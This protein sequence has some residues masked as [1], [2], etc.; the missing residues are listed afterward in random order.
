[1]PETNR[2]PH[3]PGSND[4]PILHFVSWAHGPTGSIGGTR[5][6]GAFPP[7]NIAFDIDRLNRSGPN[8]A[9]LNPSTATVVTPVQERVPFK[10]IERTVPDVLPFGF[11]LSP[12][13]PPDSTPV[14]PS[15]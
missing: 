12:P 6:T 14:S 9:N 7:I 4:P 13:T 2:P 3:A 11:P 15:Q 8:R 10:F 1:V 5:S